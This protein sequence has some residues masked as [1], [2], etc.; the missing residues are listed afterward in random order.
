MREYAREIGVDEEIF[1]EEFR[2]VPVMSKEEFGKIG[3]ALYSLSKQLSTFA[4]QNVQQARFITER[5]KIEAELELHRNH[6][7]EL[8]EIRTKE[9]EEINLQLIREI[10]REKEIEKMLKDSLDTEKHLSELKSRFIS[11]ASHEFKTPLTTVLSSV[12]LIERYGKNWEIEKFNKHIFRIKESVDSLTK[13]L[14]DVLTISRSESGKMHNN[15]VNLDVREMCSQFIE[16]VRSL[17][18]PSHQLDYHFHSEEK[19]FNLDPKLMRYVI[20]NL[21]S[22]AIKY[23][24]DGGKVGL[25]FNRGNSQLTFTVTD[26]GI[27]IPDR[28][29]N[30]LCEP[31]YRADNAFGFE[32]TGLGLSIVKRALDIMDGTIKFKSQL[33]K[34]TIVEINIPG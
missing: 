5:R 24:P 6:L 11:M 34:G 30:N 23:S 19:I 27:G 33:G 26:E 25:S 28:D 8:V 2:K 4:Y 32:G 20:I 17:A 7:E 31:F 15:P 21:L 10:E 29:E 1:I 16:E 14:D 3:D 13:L 22:N 12:E 18:G 9:I